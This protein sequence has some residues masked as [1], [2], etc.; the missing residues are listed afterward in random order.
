M[1]V[2]KRTWF[3]PSAEEPIGSLHKRAPTQW[4]E[5]PQEQRCVEEPS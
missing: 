2:P 5:P 1:K 4:T 3:E